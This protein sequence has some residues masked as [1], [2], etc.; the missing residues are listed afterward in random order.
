MR[1]GTLLYST[2][3]SFVR[4]TGGAQDD[5]RGLCMTTYELLTGRSIK[6]ELTDQF[7]ALSEDQKQRVADLCQK[8]DED[9]L[10][11]CVQ[12]VAAE[13][14]KLI[15]ITQVPPQSNLLISASCCA[16]AICAKGPG[17][18]VAVAACI[19]SSRCESQA[20]GEASIPL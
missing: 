7:N 10:D 16:Q 5:T 14:L 11:G 3:R 8:I 19:S 6:D 20:I 9:E 12:A 18:V 4:D 17:F 1:S 13:Y 2:P 15:G